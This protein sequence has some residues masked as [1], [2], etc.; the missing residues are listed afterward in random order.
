GRVGGVG[1][2]VL[3]CL[4]L[5]QRGWGQG[6]AFV[7]GSVGLVGLLVAVFVLRPVSTILVSAVRDDA[8]AFGPRLFVEKLGDRGVWGLDCLG[9]GLRCGVAWNT[10]FLGLLVGIGS[11]LLG[12]AFALVA[13]RTAFPLK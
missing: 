9:G 7:G 3:V 12:L 11:T 2:V 8:G 13:T 1:C 10:L 5:G 6:D 4:G